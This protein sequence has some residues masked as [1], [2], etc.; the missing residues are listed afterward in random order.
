[1]H[2]VSFEIK[3]HELGQVINAAGTRAE[4]HISC[5][6]AISQSL[7]EPTVFS[8]NLFWQAKRRNL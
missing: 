8:Y 7:V 6:L 2:C 1:M 5:D 4:P 3:K